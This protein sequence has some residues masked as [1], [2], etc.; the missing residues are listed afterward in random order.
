MN[1]ENLFRLALVTNSHAP[2]TL[3]KYIAL[4]SKLVIVESDQTSFNGNTLSK[5][6][7]QRY[8]LEFS[9]EEI[10]HALNFD[11]DFELNTLDCFLQEKI[12]HFCKY[13]S[14][15]LGGEFLCKPLQDLLSFSDKS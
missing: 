1:R 8:D 13:F 7:K 11:Q 2:Q 3:N 14:S 5:L 9:N 15:P 6:I 10:V 4:L 12:P